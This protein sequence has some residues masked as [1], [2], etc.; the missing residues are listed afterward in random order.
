[1][2]TQL[3]TLPPSGKGSRHCT[4]EESNCF[5]QDKSFAGLDA[6]LVHSDQSFPLKAGLL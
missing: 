3:K 5:C 4:A 6:D 1:M 2:V